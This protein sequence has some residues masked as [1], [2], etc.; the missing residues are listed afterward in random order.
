[1]RRRHFVPELF[2]EIFHNHP[3]GMLIVSPS[4]NC[5]DANSAASRLLGLPRNKILKR[6]V[7]PLLSSSTDP[8]ARKLLKQILLDSTN[9]IEFK[10]AR[11][12]GSYVYMSISGNNLHNGNSLI[13]LRDVTKPR[14]TEDA[15]RKQA[16]MLDFA[17]DTI[18]IRDL[19]DIISYWNQGAERL[20]GWNREEAIGQYVHT[21]LKT[22]FPSPLEKVLKGCLRTGHW[23]GIL[24]HSKRDGTP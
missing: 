17:N 11:P 15:V 4:G 24:T 7:A 9:E 21:F 8:A 16:Q 19:N 3:S 14:Q 12:D 13:V 6:T 5:I 23:K 10:Y 20:Y 18:M 22:V 2:R 1:M